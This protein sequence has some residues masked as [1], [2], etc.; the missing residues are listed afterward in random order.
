MATAKDVLNV[1]ICE[2]TGE[3]AQEEHMTLAA[4]TESSEPS[5]SQKRASSD[6]QHTK[7]A[8]TEQ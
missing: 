8:S 3:P 1:S 7:S 5:A 2:D 6:S 4:E